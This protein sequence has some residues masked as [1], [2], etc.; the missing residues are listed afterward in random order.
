VPPPNGA[1]LEPPLPP[2]PLPPL[3]LG[4]LPPLP[5]APPAPVY[6]YTGRYD[7]T[8]ARPYVRRGGCGEY[9]YWNGEYCADAR[10]R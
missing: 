7:A 8:V 1:P 2:G 5:R 3:L 4:V 6:G 10:N 9:R